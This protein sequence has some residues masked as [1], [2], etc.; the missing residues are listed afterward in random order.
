M[1]QEGHLVGTAPMQQKVLVCTRSRPSL[2]NDGV[3]DVKT[4][5]SVVFCPQLNIAFVLYVFETWP[6]LA[7]GSCLAV[8]ECSAGTV[9][10]GL[11]CTTA[12]R[13]LRTA[14]VQPIIELIAHSHSQT[15]L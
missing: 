8:F 15:A 4:L 10:A 7:I 6:S 12:L 11:V 13:A 3:H 9:F 14:F 2:R 1:S 5:H